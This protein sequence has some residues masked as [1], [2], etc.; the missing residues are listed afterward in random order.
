MEW[1]IGKNYDIYRPNTGKLLL[2]GAQIWWD[3][4]F[5]RWAKRSRI[6]SNWPFSFIPKG[7]SPST[8]PI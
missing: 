5:T 8:A 3:M 1:A 7:R 4:H 6:T 2:P